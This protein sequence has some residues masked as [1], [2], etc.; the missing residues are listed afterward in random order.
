SRIYR[1]NADETGLGRRSRTWRL[2][3]VVGLR[4]DGVAEGI[5]DP[6]FLI[7]ELQV[8]AHG[9]S[10]GID[11][12]NLSRP[13]SA[14]G[15]LRD[16]NGA[17]GDVRVDHGQSA[18]NEFGAFVRQRAKGSDED[19]TGGIES[20]H[21]FPWTE[22]SRPHINK[23]RDLR[24]GRHNDAALSAGGAVRSGEGERDYRVIPTGIGNGEGSSNAAAGIHI[25]G[26]MLNR[27]TRTRSRFTD[28]DSILPV[29]K[30]PH[31]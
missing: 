20:Q 31:T 5:C 6:G 14:V 29:G 27:G 15:K 23:L 3:T 8:S 10:G 26:A 13:S 22:V 1:N 2:E 12:D 7:N 18:R 21:G 24:S 28:E 25:N 19:G 17:L 4:R 16:E 30:D 9:L 11:H